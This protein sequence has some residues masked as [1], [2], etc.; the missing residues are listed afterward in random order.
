M[1][2]YHQNDIKIRQL[3][4]ISSGNLATVLSNFTTQ[5]QKVKSYTHCV[6]NWIVLMLGMEMTA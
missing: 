1:K 3:G 4:M 5:T 6:H 2:K